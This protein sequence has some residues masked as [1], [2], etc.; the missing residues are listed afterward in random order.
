MM[1]PEGGTMAQEVFKR[2]EKKYLLTQEQYQKL[3]LILGGVMDMD[4]YGH[5]TICNIYL[6]TP[7]YELIRTSIEKPVYK[8]KVRLRCYGAR[9]NDSSPVF[10]ELK[11]KYDSVVYKRRVGMDMETARR[12]V[13]YGIHP[14]QDGQI[15]R[16]VD[17]AV[18]RYG[19]R[20]MA[21]ISYERDAYTCQMDRELRITFDS[22]ILG[23]LGDLDLRVEPYG[24]CL[25]P[26]EQILMEVK[27][28]GAMPVWL[29]RI[30]AEQGIFPSAY[31]KYGTFY[32][33]YIYPAR[34]TG[35]EEMAGYHT[36]RQ[37][38]M[39]GGIICA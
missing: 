38:Y 14:G 27:I 16:E 9:G 8:E 1:S 31:S 4:V 18:R 28:P 32:E 13:C 22:S 21:Y 6:D 2:Y 39:Q 5:H 30:F 33:T 20:P 7:D 19:L 29:S 37:E 23:R 12:Y 10:L 15:F 24:K 35:Y 11:K 34:M 36:T 3:M 17:Y 25:L 26:P